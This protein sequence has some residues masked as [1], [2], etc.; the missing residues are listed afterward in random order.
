MKLFRGWNARDVAILTLVG[1]MSPLL[2]VL[3]ANAGSQS[4][5][6]TGSTS[7]A[8]TF[9]RKDAP[10]RVKSFSATTDK[11][12]GVLKIYAKGGGGGY[13]PTTAAAISTTN[14]WITN[15]GGA[16]TTGN[17]VVY[18]HVNGTVLYATIVGAISTTNV[19]LS[20]PLTV[21]GAAGDKLYE[22]TE[23]Y[24]AL[25]GTYGTGSGTNDRLN[26]AGSDLFVAPGDSPVYMVVDGTSASTI[27]ATVGD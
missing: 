4:K 10:L 8:V 21:A 20:S 18:Q 11:T 24:R 1:I 2:A 15:T 7:A 3:N 23:Q 5:F 9:G 17:S 13:V 12:G 27:S 19:Y 26:M 25:V 22:V 16:V 6:A 14:I